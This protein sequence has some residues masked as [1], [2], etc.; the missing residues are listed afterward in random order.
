[1]TSTSSTVMRTT[2]RLRSLPIASATHFG[3][4]WKS[5][6]RVVVGLSTPQRMPL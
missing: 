3:R 2:V 6:A 5:I 4:N 1:V